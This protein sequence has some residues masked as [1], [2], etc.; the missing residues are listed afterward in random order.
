[1]ATAQPAMRQALE[2]VQIANPVVPLVSNVTAAAV[3]DASE[4][5][6]LLVTHVRAPVRWADSIGYC[7]SNHVA[8]HDPSLPM[9]IHLHALSHVTFLLNPRQIY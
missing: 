4:I 5:K 8:R 1:M 6:R 7:Q 2:A 9:S 3:M